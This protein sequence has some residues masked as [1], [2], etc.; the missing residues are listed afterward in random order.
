MFV[1]WKLMIA[2]AGR[3]GVDSVTRPMNVSRFLS[4][5]STVKRWLPASSSTE[6]PLANRTISAGDGGL[7]SLR[8]VTSWS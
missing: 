2:P 5:I 8:L 3:N 7:R 4:R 1:S 6:S